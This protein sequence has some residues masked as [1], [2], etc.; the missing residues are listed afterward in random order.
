[1]LNKLFAPHPTGTPRSRATT[2]D[3]YPAEGPAETSETGKRHRS[4][5]P[6]DE[7]VER[8]KFPPEVDIFKNTGMKF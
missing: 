1:M 7:P 8:R 2:D 3:T 6:V 4:H 5:S